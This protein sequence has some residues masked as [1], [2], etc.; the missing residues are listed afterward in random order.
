LDFDRFGNLD[1]EQHLRRMRVV[2]QQPIPPVRHRAQCQAAFRE[3]APRVEYDLRRLERAEVLKSS[4]ART[5][6]P[7][8][9]LS[10]GTP[11]WMRVAELATTSIPLAGVTSPNQI[12]PSLQTCH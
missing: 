3:R 6:L 11:R 2:H 1:L 7:E 8:E 9:T 4:K 12:S 10:F 5:F